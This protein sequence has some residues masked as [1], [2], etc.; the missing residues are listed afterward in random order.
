MGD[1]HVSGDANQGYY[2][3]IFCSE[4]SAGLPRALFLHRD[5]AEQFVARLQEQEPTYCYKIEDY[6]IER[7]TTFGLVPVFKSPLDQ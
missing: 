2:G 3:V 5:D 7:R 6:H 4:T 1:L